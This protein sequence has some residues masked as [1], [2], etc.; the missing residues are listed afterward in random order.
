MARVALVVLIVLA[1][2]APAVAS[3][4]GTVFERRI[5][6]LVA[7]PTPLGPALL[8]SDAAAWR[9]D[10]PASGVVLVEAH[11]SDTAPFYLRANRSLSQVVLP[12]SD[13]AILL[14]QPGAWRVEVDPA[15][16][17]AV[18]IRVTFRGFVGAEGQGTPLA[19]RITDLETG[20]GCVVPGVCLP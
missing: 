17:A 14:H 8:L 10:V 3:E 15:L 13:Q 6:R 12:A 1:L 4:V 16:G 19:F 11:G 20:D 2:S 9:I 7:T 18:D 5:E